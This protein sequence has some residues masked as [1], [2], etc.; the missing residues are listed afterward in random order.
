MMK[1][2]IDFP[3]RKISRGFYAVRDADDNKTH[4]RAPGALLYSS[5]T[6]YATG[7]EDFP[8]NLGLNVLN[9]GKSF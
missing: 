7:A 4:G 5:V 6:L 3:S 8:F 1:Q 9:T 2:G